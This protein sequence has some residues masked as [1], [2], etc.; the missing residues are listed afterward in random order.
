MTADFVK[1]FQVMSL[2]MNPPPVD[3][4]LGVSVDNP[5]LCVSIIDPNNAPPYTYQWQQGSGAQPGVSFETPT[6]P[7]TYFGP[8]ALDTYYSVVMTVTNANGDSATLSFAVVSTNDLPVV[9]AG[10]NIS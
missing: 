10:P 7:C 6:S 3:G 4:V 9:Y 5:L 2:V 1:Q 8:L